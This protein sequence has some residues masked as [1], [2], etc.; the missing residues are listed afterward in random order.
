MG[1]HPRIESR[2]VASFC[3]IRSRNSRLWLIRNPALEEA[4]LGYLAKY[5]ARYGVE[6][7]A[8]AIEGNHL[9]SLARYPGANRAAFKR[10]LNSSVARAVPRY[11]KDYEGGRF[12]GCRYSSEFVPAAQDIEERF[13]YTVLQ[14]VQDGLVERISDYRGYNC[15]SDAV[16][17]VKRKFK[18]VNWAAYNDRR[19]WDSKAKLRDFTEI[20]ELQ[21]ARLPGYEGLS[22]R[23]YRQVMLRK[24]EARRQEI[25]ARRGMP[26]LGAE[27]LE[28]IEVGAK[29]KSTK[30]SGRYSHRP[31]VLCVCPKRRAEYLAWYFEI[32]YAYR[33]SS[34]R[35]RAG[36]LT[37]EFPPGTYRP[38]LYAGQLPAG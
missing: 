4:I 27:A 35:F 26:A 32:Y 30:T 22:Q 5:G 21:Y 28:R 24:L 15:F 12:W 2:E 31:R 38:V 9:H 1:Y 17:G 36:E 20:V 7:Y 23:D 34:K 11:V 3:T 16:N 6:L 29:P 37:V 18:V 13:F 14:V 10:D 33:E 25:V 19:R 8:F